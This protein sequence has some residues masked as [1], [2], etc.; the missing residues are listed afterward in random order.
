[1]AIDEN[2]P[3]LKGPNSDEGDRRVP[4]EMV[5][6]EYPHLRDYLEIHRRAQIQGDARLSSAEEKLDRFGGLNQVKRNLHGANPE[7]VVLQAC[8]DG[9]MVGAEVLRFARAIGF[10]LGPSTAHYALEGLRNPDEPEHGSIKMIPGITLIYE[11]PLF[12]SSRSW[13]IG[14]RPGYLTT[15]EGV[16]R[17]TSEPQIKGIRRWFGILRPQES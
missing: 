7:R 9:I 4:F 16:R 5:I 12:H 14:Q 1:M 6:E 3:V 8:R 10:D 17:L 11:V 2:D 13:I 15:D